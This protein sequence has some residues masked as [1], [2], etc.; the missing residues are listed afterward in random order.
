MQHERLLLSDSGA[1]S[2]R[3][4]LGFGDHQDVREEEEV[5]VLS[6]HAG[7]QLSAPIEE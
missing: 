4:L 2:R 6:L 1:G 3:R 5:S 7:F